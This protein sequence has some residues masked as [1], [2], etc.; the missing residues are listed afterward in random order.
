MAPHNVLALS[1]K[2]QQ[3]ELMYGNFLL[4]FQVS[5]PFDAASSLLFL[6]T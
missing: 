4:G 5:S 2:A 6:H 3:K 1:T